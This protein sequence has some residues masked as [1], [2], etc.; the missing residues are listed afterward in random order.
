MDPRFALA[1]VVA[2]M[3]TRERM[4]RRVSVNALRKFMNL[5]TLKATR[6]AMAPLVDEGTLLLLTSRTYLLPERKVPVRVY[7]RKPN[8][9]PFKMYFPSHSAYYKWAAR[10]PNVVITATKGHAAGAFS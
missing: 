2:G 8:G 3:T 6:A 9:Q 7:G 10:S 1:T 5:P 4:A